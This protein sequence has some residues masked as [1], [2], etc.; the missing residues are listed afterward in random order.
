MGPGQIEV[1]VDLT[2]L[3]HSSVVVLDESPCTWGS[4]RTNFQVLV[5]VLFLGHQVLALVLEAWLLVLVLESQVLDNNI[6]FE[7]TETFP[8]PELLC[9]IILLLYSARWLCGY[10]LRISD[11][12]LRTVGPLKL[13]LVKDWS[14]ETHRPSR[15]A[16]SQASSG[17]IRSLCY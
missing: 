14:A 12:L 1:H 6:R 17:P 8:G 4:S 7:T 3:P 10:M 2:V 9:Y 16:C 11:K 15:P 5:L 13:D